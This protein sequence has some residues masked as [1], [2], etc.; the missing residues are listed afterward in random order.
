MEPKKIKQS[1]EQDTNISIQKKQ[2]T[3]MKHDENEVLLNYTC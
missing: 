3:N 1:G 2:D